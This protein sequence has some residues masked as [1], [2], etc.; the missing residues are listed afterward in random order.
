M[1]RVNFVDNEKF[2]T[3]D[4]DRL[5]ALPQAYMQAF[6]EA[7]AGGQNFLMES[8]APTYTGLTGGSPDKANID[9]PEQWFGANGLIQKQ[10]LES[11]QLEATAAGRR[12]FTLYFSIVETEVEENRDIV[13]PATGVVT[14]TL[15]ETRREESRI[16]EIV[17]TSEFVAATPPTVPQ[18]GIS[19]GPTVNRIGTVEYA[20]I[21]YDGGHPAGPGTPIPGGDIAV[22]G[23][24]AVS[25]GSAAV[26]GH[27]TTHTDDVAGTD[28]LAFPTST[29]RGVMPK[30]SLDYL[31]NAV[32]EVR[33][34]GPVVSAS[35]GTNLS[36]GDF[37]VLG[38]NPNPQHYDI[39]FDYDT[40]SFQV[41][42]TTFQPKFAGPGSA[43]TFARSD[44]FSGAYTAHETQ[45]D[46]WVPADGLSKTINHT[47]GVAPTYIRIHAVHK[48]GS[49]LVRQS[50]GI[51]IGSGTSALQSDSCCVGYS[52]SSSSVT[53]MYSN[54][55]GFTAI[56]PQGIFGTGIYGRLS[57]VN[58]TVVTIGTAGGVAAIG[59]DGIILITE[60]RA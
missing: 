24:I 57:V 1:D 53:Q 54:D 13:N 40:A 11:I 30:R 31:K 20:Q 50:W 16:L 10:P 8:S 43:S 2:T 44:A 56:I 5:H 21:I 46:H 58:S 60:L 36:G 3:A 47:L 25:P 41:T 48:A 26:V 51:A 49:N 37:Q 27:N 33:S 4:A 19:A 45:F 23:T 39:T 7:F 29:T 6:A 35:D 55:K 12:R 15:I 59:A 52:I 18:S 14:S 17:E 22:T 38:S 34:T 32:I 42:G 28:L 9:V